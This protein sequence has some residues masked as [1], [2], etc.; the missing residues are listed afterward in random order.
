[1]RGEFSRN[2]HQ[3]QRVVEADGNP[4][5]VWSDLLHS[6]NSSVKT[7]TTIDDGAFCSALASFFVNKV[8]DIHCAI[9]SALNGSCP[10]PLSS[11]VP[12]SG[13]CLDEFSPAT[14]DEVLRLLKSMS[15]KSSPLDFIP[16]SLIKSSGGTF[17]CII[18]RLANL[19]FEHATFP[20]R[21]KTAQVTPLIKQQGMDASDVSSYRPISNLN[22]IS[23]VLERLVLARIVPHVSASPS[24]DSV[25]YVYH[26]GHSTETALLK[27]TNDI[28]EGFDLSL[29]HISE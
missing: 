23:K 7:S 9:S 4:R 14:E 29:I 27:I 28:F 19:T 6:G 15:A 10:D 22:T 13:P 24:F 21:Y 17:A 26:R 5:R 11:D 12:H 18:A 20:A 25:Q 16:T 1:M 2:Q 3:L 8:R